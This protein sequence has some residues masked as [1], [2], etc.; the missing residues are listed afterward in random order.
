MRHGPDLN[1]NARWQ[2]TPIHKKKKT[3]QKKNTAAACGCVCVALRVSV[4]PRRIKTKKQE[5]KKCM[6]RPTGP[7]PRPLFMRAAGEA[8]RAVVM[9]VS[10]GV[11][12]EQLG[13]KHTAPLTGRVQK[14]QLK[15]GTVEKKH[16]HIDCPQKQKKKRMDGGWEIKRENIKKR[17]KKNTHNKKK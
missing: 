14:K 12:V 13:G 16:V 3:K 4:G 2:H 6:L 17:K 10:V 9:S 1:N 11:R 15:E 7:R 5:G 8:H